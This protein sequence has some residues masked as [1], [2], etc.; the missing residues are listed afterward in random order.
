[1]ELRCEERDRRH[2]AADGLRVA[3]LGLCAECRAN[4][5]SEGRDG[6]A[7]QHFPARLLRH[8][9]DHDGALQTRRNRTR[10]DSRRTELTPRRLIIVAP[11]SDIE[12]LSPQWLTGALGGGRTVLGVRAERVAVDGGFGSCLYRLF[13]EYMTQ[14]PGPQTLILKLPSDNSD[15]LNALNEDIVF[16]EVRF[17]RDVA[18]IVDCPVPHVYFS[19]YDAASGA[20]SILMED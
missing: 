9:V 2:V 1:M 15:L 3:G 6:I 19:D 5:D 8:R 11:I 4:D 18:G 17:Y 20:S 16:R 13:P 12:E 14:D 10:P 7:V